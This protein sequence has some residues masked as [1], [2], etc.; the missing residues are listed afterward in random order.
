MKQ[1]T[2]YRCE[3]CGKTYLIAGACAKHEDEVC[4][5]NPAI[6]PLCYS[7]QHYKESWQDE[8]KERIAYYFD[9]CFGER[10][11]IKLFSP[12]RCT[13]LDCKLYNN[14]K[15]SDEMQTALSEENY[16]AMPT[17]RTGG[18]EHYQLDPKK[19]YNV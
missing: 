1:V 15:L 17:R 5:K 4:M 6:R 14:I 11:D 3:H 9:T 12:N 10:Y 8:E 7:C 2:A 18:C 19:E 16:I 13:H